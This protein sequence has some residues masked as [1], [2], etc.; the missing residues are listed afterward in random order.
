[1]GMFDRIWLS[2]PA[3]G[4]PVEFQSKAGECS[5]ADYS[6]PEGVGKIPPAVLADLDGQV[7]TC[8]KCAKILFP[9]SHVVVVIH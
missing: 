4:N 2:C 5:L 3:C 9:K 7:E 8:Q 1:M 6:Y